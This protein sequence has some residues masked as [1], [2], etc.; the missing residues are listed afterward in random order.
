MP[1]T[2]P[3]CHTPL[4]SREERSFCP[5]CLLRG[6]M[7]DDDTLDEATDD[8]VTIITEAAAPQPGLPRLPRHTLQEKI[9]EGGFANVYRALQRE[10]VRR[11]TAVKVLKPQVTSANVLARF[12]MERQ[13]LARMEHPGIA[14]LWDS[15][16]T[17]DGVPFF[18]M[19]LVRGEPV[20]SFCERHKLPLDERL[21]L[22]RQ[23]CDAVQ[24]A[25]E[26]GVL[27]RDLK[28]SNILVAVDGDDWNVKVIDFGIAKVLETAASEED[29]GVHTAI[30]QMVGTPGYMSP[31]Q[32]AGGSQ[33][34]DVRSDLYALGV[35]LYELITG[36]TPLKWERQA[37]PQSRRYTVAQHVTP[38]STL[39]DTLLLTRT[40]R[41]DMDTITRKALQQSSGL[42]YASAAAFAE[43]VQRHLQ[44]EPVLA[45]EKSWTYVTEKFT[46]RHLPLVAGSAV[47]LLAVLVG[48]TV[49]TL[50]YQREQ[51]ARA[52]VEAAQRVILSREAEL[53]R[54][55]G[56]AYFDVAQ[57]YKREGDAQSAIA[58]LSRALRQQPVFA[59]AAADL[60]MMLAQ[61]ETPQPVGEVIQ[62]DPKWGTV[63]ENAGVVNA[64]GQVL[65]VLFEKEDH[66]RLMLFQTTDQ[67]AWRQHEYPLEATVTN[68][69]L[70]GNGATLVWADER[71]QVHLA[72]LMEDG[73]VAKTSIWQSAQPVRSLAASVKSEDIFIGCADGSLW[74]REGRALESVRQIGSIPGAVTHIQPAPNNPQV[75]VGSDRGEVWEFEKRGARPARKLMQLPAAVSVLTGLGPLGYLAAG[76]TSG[77]VAVKY[78]KTPAETLPEPTRLHEGP[79]TALALTR[80]HTQLISAG[81]GTDLRVRWTDIE[82]KIDV[83]PAL[84]SPG[85]VRRILTSQGGEVAEIVSA[86]SSVRL[87]RGSGGPALTLRR[88][89]RAR[90]VCM[91]SLGRCMAVLRDSGT[92]LEILQ[93]STL[94][95][96]AVVLA[97]EASMKGETRAHDAL[98]FTAGDEQLV[99]TTDDA[100][101]WLWNL[102]DTESEGVAEWQSPALALQQTLSGPLLA[103]LFDGTL[104]EVPT[105][106][107][108]VIKRVDADPATTWALAN[109]SPDGQAAVWAETSPD[110]QKSTRVRV[111]LTGEE[112]PLNLQ[113]ERLSA[114]AIHAGVRKIAFG[115]SNGHVRILSP[116]G[117]RPMHHS[118][119]QSRVTSTAFS[120]DGKV[121]LTGSSDGTAALWH[122]T[123]LTPLADPIH[124]A[125]PVLRVCF[126]GD[127]RRFAI[128]G[129]NQAAVGDAGTRTLIGQPFRVR[130]A[131]KA[132][133]LD[134]TGT[135][136]ALTV[137]LGEVMLLDV[138][139]PQM[140]PAP[141]WFLRLAETHVSRRV[142]PQGSIEFLE[143]PGRGVTRGLLP[144]AN[145]LTAEQQ[146]WGSLAEWLFTHTGLRTLSPW[147]QHTLEDYLALIQKSPRSPQRQAE[148]QRL[149]PLRHIKS[150]PQK[151]P[152]AAPAAAPQ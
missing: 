91:S 135:R 37:D 46:R 126:S 6:M 102:S 58:S 141:E 73:A 85:L 97:K 115:L 129:A 147:S 118:L 40:E 70:S 92:A 47:A 72:D 31:E 11:E 94:V 116:R 19:E 66:Q 93:H 146:P 86:D 107:R 64:K 48:L 56:H 145:S 68:L 132:L 78:A 9:G 21:E 108:S 39:P 41:R 134:A 71:E 120:P 3:T 49:S 109:I 111:W 84:E 22:F 119:H 63:K 69:A 33:D 99:Q 26:K 127:G 90:F 50:L 87:W 121:L 130:G 29:S 98:A 16:V 32:A 18:S 55:L 24:H 53:S 113:A 104:M 23:I 12:E 38:P 77:H 80:Q 74:I 137:G 43:D 5:A 7:G 105:D 112:K 103:A 139:P 136:M 89:Q 54:T 149:N 51:K 60:Q 128:C 76:D 140:S 75:I 96:P 143:Y 81:G 106:G 28:P 83:L 117:D 35:V 15:G 57:F 67:G 61:D 124:L 4:E 122:S 125:E 101:S 114:I 151:R 59:E 13:T 62:L 52:N 131:G 42:R 95:H 17:E 34:V 133:A 79:V 144:P 45:G 110:T 44:D 82:R 123:L 30:H 150:E 20:T 1:D 27:H 138:A 14:R 10:P 148:M 36:Y 65:A 152:L 8:A 142:T 100:R 25:H 88:P 2:C